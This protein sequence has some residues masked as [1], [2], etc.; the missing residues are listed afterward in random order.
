[1]LDSIWCSS[2]APCCCARP[3]VAEAFWV[4]VALYHT[5]TQG[6]LSAPELQ[7]TKKLLSHNIFLPISIHKHTLYSLSLASQNSLSSAEQWW[8]T[9]ALPSQL[10]V[11]GVRPPRA[12]FTHTPRWHLC[13]LHLGLP[14]LLS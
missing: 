13:T 5:V 9:V 14:L 7:W 8:L 2:F 4:M 1:M 11:V 10:N 6:I 3:G 12:S